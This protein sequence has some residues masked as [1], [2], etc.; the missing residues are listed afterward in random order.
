MLSKLPFSNCSTV[1]GPKVGDTITYLFLR[2]LCSLTGVA[3]MVAESCTD[4]SATKQRSKT[5]QFD[6]AKSFARPCPFTNLV[7]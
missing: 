4:C 5:C 6:Y 7:G 3:G 2:A 1:T